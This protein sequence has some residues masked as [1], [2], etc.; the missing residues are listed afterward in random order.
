MIDHSHFPHFHLQEER[1]SSETL[2][3]PD[4]TP[5]LWSLHHPCHSEGGEMQKQTLAYL[6]KDREIEISPSLAMLTVLP[7]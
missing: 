5:L 3:N 7:L 2:E 4:K 1:G 6:W